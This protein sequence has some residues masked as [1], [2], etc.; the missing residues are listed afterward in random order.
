MSNNS[1]ENEM[2]CF[3]FSS[4]QKWAMWSFPIQSTFS[5]S[6]PG[7]TLGVCLVRC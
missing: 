2:S 4:G 1:F 3:Y 7:Q 6:W 5:K